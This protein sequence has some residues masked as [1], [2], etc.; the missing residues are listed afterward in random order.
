[1][2][3]FF[4]KQ[5]IINRNFPCCCCYLA[6][7]VEGEFLNITQVTRGLFKYRIRYLFLLKYKLIIGH[8]SN[9]LINPK[10]SFLF[11]PTDDMGAYLCIASNSVPPSVSKRII[12]HVNCK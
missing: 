6:K 11:F 4:E 7:K 10:K 3:F 12:V 5:I 9:Y 2:F 1:M 8:W